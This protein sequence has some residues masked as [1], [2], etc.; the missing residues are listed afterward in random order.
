M[1]SYEALCLAPA[2]T[3][4]ATP[5]LPSR[6]SSECVMSY[7]RWLR[8]ADTDKMTFGQRRG[9]SLGCQVVWHMVAHHVCHLQTTQTVLQLCE[10]TLPKLLCYSQQ[11]GPQDSESSDS[12]S[13]S[14]TCADK[15]IF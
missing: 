15:S 9:R 5:E 13:Q 10:L 14:M 11:L 12:H 7:V 4:A 2:P 6:E 3:V 1:I 8:N